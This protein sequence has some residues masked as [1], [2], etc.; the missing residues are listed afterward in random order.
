MRGRGKLAVRVSGFTLLAICGIS[1]FFLRERILERWFL[2][3]IATGRPRQ[4]VDACD[5]LRPIV[6]ESSI[7]ALIRFAREHRRQVLDDNPTSAP[8]PATRS[9][10]WSAPAT[11]M[12]RTT[13]SAAR[14]PAR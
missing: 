5:R 6:S 8:P 4:I 12:P 1:A 9:P 10:P 7:P 11:T 14:P 13:R 3:R 2:H